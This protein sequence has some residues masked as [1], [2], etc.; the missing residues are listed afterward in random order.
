M[1]EIL[2]R[3]KS[4]ENGEWVEGYYGYTPLKTSIEEVRAEDFFPR[5]WIADRKGFGCFVDPETVGQFTGLTDK[6]GVKI[7]EGDIVNIK[8]H[9]SY[10]NGWYK[11][12]YDTRNHYWALKR[13]PEYSHCYLTFSALNG[14]AEDS[15]VIG[16]IFDNPELVE[17]V[18]NA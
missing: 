16:N 9:V 11:V 15:E 6:N 7:F 13:D 2:F 14:F 17:E 18:T 5:A 4:V 3:G 1:R 12:V 8:E 10:I